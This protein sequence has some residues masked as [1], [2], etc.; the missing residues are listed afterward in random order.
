MVVGGRSGGGGRVLFQCWGQTRGQTPPHITHWGRG[1]SAFIPS[2]PLVVLTLLPGGAK[3]HPPP[4][5]SPPLPLTQRRGNSFG[6]GAACGTPPQLR[7]PMLRAERMAF[8][9]VQPLAALPTSTGLS[10]RPPPSMPPHVPG[11]RSP[12]P[13]PVTTDLTPPKGG[14]K[15][16][17]SEWGRGGEP[18]APPPLSLTEAASPPCASSC[19][20]PGGFYA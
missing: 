15:K 8:E 14:G 12:L 19:A 5:L 9:A 16:A 3:I 4:P 7:A 17:K 18:T 2:P 13:A 11:E 10:R 1:P 6:E 20:P